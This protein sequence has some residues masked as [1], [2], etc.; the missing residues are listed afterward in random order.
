MLKNKVS[1]YINDLNCTE[2]KGSK[3]NKNLVT[4][5]ICNIIRNI[6]KIRFYQESC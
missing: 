1:K 6:Y 2:I 5:Y 4:N 3:S